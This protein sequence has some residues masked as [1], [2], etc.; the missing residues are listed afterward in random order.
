VGQLAEQM[1]QA[2]LLMLTAQKQRNMQQIRF[3]SE[4]R[5]A[6]G[7]HTSASR[8]DETPCHPKLKELSQEI[9]VRRAQQAQS[10]LEYYT[11]MK[12]P[13]H[14]PPLLSTD[15]SHPLTRFNIN[16]GNLELPHINEVSRDLALNQAK[17]M[18][19][20]APHHENLNLMSPS[21]SDTLDYLDQ[22]SYLNP[23]TRLNFSKFTINTGP[24]ITPKGQQLTPVAASPQDFLARISVHQ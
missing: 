11:F 10:T 1:S 7:G 22:Q 13:S 20:Y 5:A 6:G 21:P 16:S 15:P 3:K 12:S 4:R 19:H 2:Q 17:R 8:L 24:S 14:F 18:S 23:G 9:E